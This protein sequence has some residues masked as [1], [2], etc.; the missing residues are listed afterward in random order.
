MYFNQKKYQEGRV[1]FFF[2]TCQNLNFKIF[3]YSFQKFYIFFSYYLSNLLPPIIWI[4]ILGSSLLTSLLK[5]NAFVQL[6]IFSLFTLPIISSEVYCMQ[7]IVGL[8]PSRL[9]A[10]IFPLLRSVLVW[11][12]PQTIPHTA[13]PIGKCNTCQVSG[14]AT[15]ELYATSYIINHS[16]HQLLHFLKTQNFYSPIKEA[17]LSNMSVFTSALMLAPKSSQGTTARTD[18]SK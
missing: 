5:V 1:G 6:E 12:T 17:C 8:S 2:L 11:M 4:I 7:T 13:L 9:G 10:E 15:V 16:R 14:P 18:H 3:L